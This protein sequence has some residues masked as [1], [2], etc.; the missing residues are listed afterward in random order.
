M[1]RT[2]ARP[3]IVSSA[4]GPDRDGT[5]PTCCGG[6]SGVMALPRR[7]APTASAI[8]CSNWEN[9]ILKEFDRRP[10]DG[11]DR[12]HRHNPDEEAS[13]KR[14][15]RHNMTAVCRPEHVIS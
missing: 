10:G 4:C 8:G 11:R 15:H 6:M 13:E 1:S 14:A 3:K 7:S 2:V 5:A 12:N 9:R